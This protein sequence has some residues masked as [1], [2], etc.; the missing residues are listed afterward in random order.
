MIKNYLYNITFQIFNIIIPIITIPYISRVLG[1]EGLG[2]SAYTNSVTQYFVL[3]SSLGVALYGSRV[4]AAHRDNK[5][6]LTQSF[7]E[8]IIVKL[9]LTLLSLF[10]FIIYIFFLKP[11][12]QKPLLYQL[13]LIMSVFFDISWFFIGLEEFKKIVIR[14]MI[15][16]IV[17]V[18]LIFVFVKSPK[19]LIIYISILSFSQLLGNIT[20]WTYLPGLLSIEKLAPFQI[21]THLLQS[22]ALF[23]PQVSVVISPL[24]MRTMLGKFSGITD[25][26]YYDNSD[27]IIKMLLTFTTSIAFVIIPK[28][29]NEFQKG[30]LDK[31]N[32]LLIKSIELTTA[33][34]L[35]L[36]FGLITISSRFSLYFFGPEFSMIGLYISILAPTLYITAMSNILGRQYLIST[37]QE[38]IYNKAIIIST[39]TLF[40]AVYFIV[41]K[42]G[43][44]GACI[45]I[46]FS[47]IL[48]LLVLVKKIKS[49]LSINKIIKMSYKYFISSVVMFIAIIF[50]EKSLDNSL[51][52]LFFL[53]IIGVF[54][55]II[56]LMVNKVSL[57]DFIK[58]EIKGGK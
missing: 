31:V 39:L 40:F 24:I 8:I 7:F 28:V 10:L 35:P 9:I 27:K 41:P 4:I 32:D 30:N 43:V 45:A 51:I 15:V 25:V 6:K 1:K 55:Y 54:I 18:C 48:L 56:L 19:D 26:A 22:V 33:I 58:K 49:V 57:L 42:L 3:L 13:P 17:S 2:V 38:N 16:K 36:V 34:S 50:F 21:K 37:R 11:S 52:N 12:F 20:F 44:L 14:N 23:I 29:S 5:Q 46:V 53:I 47:E